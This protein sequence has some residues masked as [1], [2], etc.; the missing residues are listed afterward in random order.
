MGQTVFI[1]GALVSLCNTDFKCPECGEVHSEKDWYPRFFKSKHGTIS[2]QCKN[3]DCKKRLGIT[4]DMRG[5]VVVWLKSKEKKF[6][7]EI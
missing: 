2:R 3:E 6:K 7:T 4:T 5:D 1:A